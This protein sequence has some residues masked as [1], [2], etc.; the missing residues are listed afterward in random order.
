MCSVPVIPWCLVPEWAGHACWT[1]A[2]QLSRVALTPRAVQHQASAGRGGSWPGSRE[3]GS[4]LERQGRAPSW[5]G[6]SP[7]G[8]PRTLSLPPPRSDPGCASPSRAP[9]PALWAVCVVHPPRSAP[10]PPLLQG[11]RPH[12]A[13]SV[14]SECPL[15]PLQASGPV[16]RTCNVLL[17][18]FHL[19]SALTA[20]LC[21]LPPRNETGG[22]VHMVSGTGPPDPG[23][24]RWEPQTG[25]SAAGLHEA[26]ALCFSDRSF[27]GAGL[28][29]WHYLAGGT[30][31]CVRP[32][33][34]TLSSRTRARPAPGLPGEGLGLCPHGLWPSCMTAPTAAASPQSGQAP[35]AVSARGRPTGPRG[36]RRA[37]GAG[38][39]P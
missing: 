11:R 3:R 31:A 39:R 26:F 35:R 5:Q 37:A 14:P 24:T 36:S 18:D 2:M 21:T 34:G 8:P 29:C 38:A 7:L 15:R 23:R 32:G 20:S 28:W 13:L 33:R 22:H 19:R 10:G 16:W 9:A 30:G 25:V 17:P 27:P 12:P 1:R 4:S 6:M